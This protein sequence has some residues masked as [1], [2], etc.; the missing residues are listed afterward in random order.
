LFILTKHTKNN[1][2]INLYKEIAHNSVY[3]MEVMNPPT[4]DVAQ[5]EFESLVINVEGSVGEHSMDNNPT[6]ASVNNET[7]DME[8]MEEVKDADAMGQYIGQCKWFNNSY[9]YGFITIWDGPE[10]GTDIFVHHSG[11]KPLN[12]MYKTLKKGEYVMFDVS[13]GDKGKQAVNV[14]GICNGPLLCDHI[15]VRRGQPDTTSPPPVGAPMPG[16]PTGQPPV[17]HNPNWNTVSYKKKLPPVHP[18]NKRRRVPDA[19]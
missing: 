3:T 9:G 17:P 14:R 15:Q 8:V 16:Q 19:K 1:S 18:G 13:A 2:K 7:L 6:D 10:K 4:V 5:A 12:S 11:I